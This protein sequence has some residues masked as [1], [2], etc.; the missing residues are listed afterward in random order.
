MIRKV[1]FMESCWFSTPPFRNNCCKSQLPPTS[2]PPTSPNPP[3]RGSP[4][5]HQEP[6]LASFFFRFAMDGS[7]LRSPQCTAWLM[8]SGELHAQRPGHGRECNSETA[9]CP[10]PCQDVSELSIV[11]LTLSNKSFSSSRR[12]RRGRRFRCTHHRCALRASARQLPSYALTLLRSA[13]THPLGFAFSFSD[14]RLQ[15]F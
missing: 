2:L 3:V 4:I 11:G 10:Y 14:S 6:Y 13:A 7:R 5:D 1:G 12:R 15:L 9:A 8:R